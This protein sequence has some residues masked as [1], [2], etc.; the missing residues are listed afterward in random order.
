MRAVLDGDAGVLRTVPASTETENPSWIHMHPNGHTLYAVEEGDPAGHVVRLEPCPDGWHVVQRMQT[1]GSPCHLAM[2]EQREFLFVSN[3]SSGSLGVF[4]LDG[5]GAI[6]EMTEMLHHSGHG[7][8]PERQEGPHVHSAF[9]SGETVY[10]ADLGLDSI[11]VYDLNRQDGTLAERM[12]IPVEQGAGPRHMVLAP[13][14]PGTMYV[15]GELSGNVYQLDLKKG[16]CISRERIIPEDYLDDARVSAIRVCG[17]T[18]YIG[19]RECNSVTMFDIREDGSLGGRVFYPHAQETPRDVWM[20]ENWCITADEGSFGLTLL[21]RE[22][23]HLSQVSF[24]ATP[25]VKPTCILP[26]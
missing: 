18:V 17:S 10:V 8:N 12:R 25:G 19:C 20:N 6:V 13:G 11:F 4:R 26:L 24:T 3:Y 2:D 7:P 21:R 14:H 16:C 9:C 23:K 22:G 15:V 5:D 1:E